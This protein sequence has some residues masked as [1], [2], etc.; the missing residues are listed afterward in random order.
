ML[1][2]FLY[3]LLLSVTFS[4]FGS[5]F[6]RLLKICEASHPVYV[7]LSGMVIYGILVW[8]VIF[9]TG[10][11]FW[12]QTAFFG[13]T[14]L[15]FLLDKK[16]RKPIGRLVLHFKS[17]Q[18]KYQVLWLVFLVLVLFQ[19]TNVSSLPDNFSYYIQTIK[20]ANEQGLVPGLMNLHPFLGQFSAWHIL[21]AG[22][23][24]GYFNDIN[25]LLVLWL[26][27][28]AF[29]KL[30]D[31]KKDA[32][33]NW[34]AFLPLSSFLFLPFIDSPSPD[35][36]VILLSQLVFYLFIKNYR[37]PVKNEILILAILSIFSIFIKLTALPN[38][39]LL[40]IIIIKNRKYLGAN[41]KKIFV[42]F[43][44][45]ISFLLIK[46]YI[47][48]G[49]MFY[50]FSFAHNLFHPDWQYPL[51][52]LQYLSDLGAK[53]AYALHFNHFIFQDFIKWILQLGWHLLVNISFVFML[54]IFPFFIKN[55][56]NARALFLVYFL[57]LLYFLSILFYAPNFRFFLQFYFFF[58]LVI[59]AVIFKKKYIYVINVAGVIL[60]FLTFLGLLNTQNLSLRQV[61]IPQKN[62][63][64]K[65]TE[66]YKDRIGNLDY[67]RFK[68]SRDYFWET[69]DAPLPAVQKKQIDYFKQYFHFMP[70]RRSDILLR[71]GFYPKNTN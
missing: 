13:M 3:F 11:N 7:L 68:Y 63:N 27:F 29:D 67:Y 16:T 33:S 62:L 51:P 14:V 17:W 48:T 21:Q 12:W 6:L 50:P 36:A 18:K 54:V 9:F 52:A 42:L 44:L 1:L 41:I 61:L 49:Y 2:L 30:G 57:G 45:S 55:K 40:L 39:I 24:F 59:S 37:H 65:T 58:F 22:V 69:G 46:N 56:P 70:Q 23:N 8:F 38:L 53:E 60:F 26:L 4:V 31:L 35:L 19:S 15:F 34:I 20:W 28:F 43:T 32:P 25:G 5:F 47:L 71:S 64:V 10:F 66:Y